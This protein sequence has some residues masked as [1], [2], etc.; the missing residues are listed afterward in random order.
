MQ[1]CK[2]MNIRGLKL[3]ILYIIY[4]KPKSAWVTSAKRRLDLRVCAA[5]RSCAASQSSAFHSLLR[6]MGNV[7]V[8]RRALVIYQCWWFTPSLSFSEVWT[9]YLNALFPRPLDVAVFPSKQPMPTFSPWG[10]AASFWLFI[11]A[12][13]LLLLAWVGL[14]EGCFVLPGPGDQGFEFF[15]WY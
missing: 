1:I 10:Q 7:A 11:G 3:Y 8:A 13:C 14:K 15:H 12:L 9:R 5:G 6:L 2:R 4:L